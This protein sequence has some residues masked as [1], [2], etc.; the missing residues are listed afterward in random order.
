VNKIGGAGAVD[1]SIIEG[2]RKRDLFDGFVF[3]G[4]LMLLLSQ[5]FIASRRICIAWPIFGWPRNTSSRIAELN[6]VG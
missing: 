4:V 2:E 1:N 6:A 5:H 3:G